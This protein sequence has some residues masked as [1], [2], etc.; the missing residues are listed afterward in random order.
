MSSSVVTIAWAKVGPFSSWA[1]CIISGECR[2]GISHQGD[3]VAKFLG[4]PGGGLDAGIGQQT[5]DD[6]VGY[7]PLLEAKIQVGVGKTARAP[8]LGNHDVTGF[9]GKIRVPFPPHS[10]RAKWC[11]CWI[12][13]WDGLG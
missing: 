12:L 9:R 1:A 5:D 11:M 2:G 4:V 8:V 7:A 3:V 6:H 10:P 13:H